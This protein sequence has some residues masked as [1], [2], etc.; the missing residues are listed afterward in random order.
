MSDSIAE[1]LK[2]TIL[3][4]GGYSKVSEETGISQSTLVRSAAGKTEPKFKDI[5]AI[6]KVTQTSLNYLAYGED[7]DEPA[8]AISGM[9]SV[10]EFMMKQLNAETN[11][12]INER[13]EELEHKIANVKSKL[14]AEELEDAAKAFSEDAS[15]IVQK[16][17]QE[18]EKQNSEI[19]ESLA[20]KTSR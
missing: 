6:A 15:K 12:V 17:S 9:S 20:Q 8:K 2:E 10:L 14:E 1:R 5:V 19:Q 18:A 13:F 4:N 16:M 11:K 7:D 3:K